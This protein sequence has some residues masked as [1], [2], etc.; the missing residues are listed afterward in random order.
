MTILSKIKLKFLLPLTYLSMLI[1]E[2]YRGGELRTNQTFQYGRFETRMKASTGSGIVN[3]F[4]LYR[5]YFA[6]GLNGSQHWNEI[7]IELL[8]RYDNRVTTNLIIQ[9]QWD[10]PD[11]AFVN[12]NPKENFHN[13]AIE[14]TP[15]Y[16]AFFVDDMLIRYINNFYVD[17]LYHPQQLM[18]NIWQPSAI[19][20]AGSFDESTLPSYAFYDW[21]KYYAYVP[22]TGNTGTNN[23]FIELW[24]DDFDDYDRDRWSKA[25][26]SFDGNNA[27]FT[28]AN[29]V[30]ESGY[31]ILCLTTPGDTGY[32]GEPLKV[33]SDQLPQ[34][35]QIKPPYPNPFNG[36][37]SIPIKI[38]KNSLINFNVYD[39]NGDI[40]YKSN[41]T[42]PPNTEKNIFWNGKNN[43]GEIV[44]SGTYLLKII[45]GRLTRTTKVIFI[46]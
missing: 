20:W 17:S 32:S 43:N 26:H 31:M 7:D 42:Y 46:K 16:I 29:V 37:I 9:N 23:N 33:R 30:F 13:Y 44:S 28:Y 24:K 41:L 36:R 34:S 15:D 25:S 27:D 21:A 14:W 40:V 18:M 10:L 6:E 39:I 19:S 11:Q 5:D 38:N 45:H 22:G 35:F 2:P 8:G 12:F 3:S 4:F 1:A